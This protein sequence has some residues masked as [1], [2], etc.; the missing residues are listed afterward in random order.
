MNLNNGN[1]NFQLLVEASP[2]ALILVNKLGHIVYVNSF[3]ERV[4]LYKREELLNK[5]LE[6]LI[7][8]EERET[9]QIDFSEYFKAPVERQMGPN[10]ELFAVKKNE[11]QFPVEIGLTPIVSENETL[12]LATINDLSERKKAEHQFKSVVEAAPSALLLANSEG[13]IEMVNQ[14]AEKLFGY[15]RK[16]FIGQ[17]IEML[18]PDRFK[19]HHPKLRKGFHSNPTNRAMG[20]G[21]DLYAKHKDGHEFPIEIGLSS[22]PA[23][24]EMH[25]LASIIDISERKKNEEA[26]KGYTQKIEAKNE[27]L[28]Q[29]TYIASHDLREPLNS[30]TS[31]IMLI[32]EDEL[33]HLEEATRVKLNYIEESSDRMRSLIEALLDYGRL[34]K[35][36]EQVS[37][38]M[39]SIIASVQNDLHDRIE[40]SEAIIT[41]DNLPIVNGF[42]VELRLLLQN[43]ISNAIKYTAKDTTPKVHISAVQNQN[44]WQFAVTDNGIGIP[45]SQ[46]EKIFLLFQRLHARDQYGGIGIGLAHCKKIMDMHHG[47]LWVES[48]PGKGSTFYFTL[49]KI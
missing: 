22:I 43:L 23:R 37:V 10:R 4:F 31:L 8:K 45:K 5:K 42:I 25:V 26:L 7:P 28:E 1:F 34:G 6:I 21:R 47:Q 15:S 41:S 35:N 14:L 18:V 13:K 30:I 19:A 3:T 38:D 24:N 36:A 46:Q 27:E 40:K 48:E 33:D 2:I 44:H 9:H 49:S 29:F 17:K 32:K 16:D 39:N 11:E 20:A 12:V